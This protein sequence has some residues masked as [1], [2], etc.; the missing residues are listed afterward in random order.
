MH[1]KFA[2][3]LD[4]AARAFLHLRNSKISNPRHILIDIEN[5]SHIMGREL[6]KKKNRS[7]ISKVRRNP[8]SKKKILSNHIV[9][10]NWD[11]TQTLAQNYRR[12]GLTSKLNKNTG[13]VERKPGD[14]VHQSDP[15]SI[16]GRRKKALE[17][18]DIAEAKIE[19]DPK[20]GAILRIVDEGRTVRP[21]P[22]NDPLLELDSDREDDDV[23]DIDQHGGESFTATHASTQSRTAVVGLLEEEANRPAAKYQRKQPEGEREFIEKLVRK[24]GD[25][26][27]AM[28]RDIKINYMQRSPA[29]LRRRVKKWREQGGL[30]TTT[31]E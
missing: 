6:Q 20:T 28:S 8:K 22:L 17:E 3:A 9:A 18:I 2:L 5:K 4:G 26:Y 12:L 25:D 7:G 24:Y 10:A 13:G 14:E 11:K 30:V 1:V 27:T 31:I 23:E 19:R 15:L 16:D 29:D 21:N